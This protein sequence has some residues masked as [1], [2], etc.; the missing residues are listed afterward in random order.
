MEAFGKR[1]TSRKSDENEEGTRKRIVIK[2]RTK[3]YKVRNMK[4]KAERIQEK[5]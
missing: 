3:I 5:W 4:K 1:N 2:K